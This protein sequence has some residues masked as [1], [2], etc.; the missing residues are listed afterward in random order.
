M[1]Y[2]KIETN[3]ELICKN[4]SIWP[5]L[6]FIKIIGSEC[7]L[8]LPFPPSDVTC[9]DALWKKVLT[10]NRTPLMLSLSKASSVT[11]YVL[12]HR[13]SCLTHTVKRAATTNVNLSV[14]LV[15]ASIAPLIFVLILYLLVSSA[16][17]FR[18]QFGPWSDP[19]ERQAYPVSKLLK[20][21][22]VFPKEIFKKN[23]FDRNQQTTKSMKK[24][25]GCRELIYSLCCSCFT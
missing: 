20:T 4:E 16:D 12:M 14:I 21:L 11:L 13:I 10:E 24:Y 5:T 18:K 8:W 7:T 23:V 1:Q 25:T 17:N 6:I 9:F 22:M 15:S 19:T 3:S 2:S